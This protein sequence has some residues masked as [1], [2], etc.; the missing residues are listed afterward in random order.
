MAEQPTARPWFA[1]R[2]IGAL[3]R[4][5]VTVLRWRFTVIGDDHLPRHGGAVITWNHHGHLDFLPVGWVTYSRTRRPLRFL[6]LKDFFGTRVIGPV[7]RIGRVIPVA[8]DSESARDALAEAIVALRE[9]HLVMVAPEGRLQDSLQVGP[10]R[11]GAVRMAQA[12]GVPIVATA[13]IGVEV[14]STIDRPWNRRALWRL[15]VAVQVAAPRWVDEAEDVAVVAE[16]LRATTQAMV[17]HLRAAA[18]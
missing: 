4:I 8:R 10:W 9:G 16:E 13:S 3:A 7:L 11:P 15:P 17:D 14:V 1:W 12:A 5:F 18:S 2:V 6:G